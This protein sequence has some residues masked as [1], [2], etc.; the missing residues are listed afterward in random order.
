MLFKNRK[1]SGIL[2][3]IILI[4]FMFSGCTSSESTTESNLK[5]TS[6]KASQVNRQNGN[7]MFSF[8]DGLYL[9]SDFEGPL[10]IYQLTEEGDLKAVLT[11]PDNYSEAYEA[12][13]LLSDKYIYMQIN[14]TDESETNLIQVNMD[15]GEWE[16]L[17]TGWFEQTD[18]VGNLLV[19]LKDD[20]S[21]YHLY[22]KDEQD[23]AIKIATID[24]D[25]VSSMVRIEDRYY[26][27]GYLYSDYMT[28]CVDLNGDILEDDALLKKLRDLDVIIFYVYDTDL[29]YGKTHPEEQSGLDV[30]RLNLDTLESQKIITVNNSMSRISMDENHIYLMG[31]RETSG[32]HL[33][34]F[35]K[36]GENAIEYT[37]PIEYYGGQP[38]MTYL[39]NFNG[40]VYLL[41]TIDSTFEGYDESF[42]VNL[43]RIEDDG[44]V[45]LYGKEF[46]IDE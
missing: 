12:Q 28:Y 35:D 29:I 38:L 39:Y 45:H 16:I 7:Q 46:F 17:D 21:E 34:R 2:I 6:D 25:R 41:K 24:L 33:W 22:R 27:T 15:D 30:Y 44:L 5:N 10:S 20:D 23:D 37:D 43:Y 1:K 18:L 31:R 19:Y 32:Y 11:F 26:I 42:C 36:D 13:C 4:V 40:N 3:C 9:V 14:D 8:N